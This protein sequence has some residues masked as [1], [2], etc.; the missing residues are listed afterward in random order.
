LFWLLVT[1]MTVIGLANILLL[2]IQSD[3]HGFDAIIFGITQ[4][5]GYLFTLDSPNGNKGC[6][7]WHGV[8]VSVSWIVSFFGWMIIP[9]TVGVVVGR[10]QSQKVL[11]GDIDRQFVNIATEAAPD[12]PVQQREILDRLRSNFRKF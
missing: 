6:G 5:A 8:T 4:T 9:V 7:F 1:S 2:A 12:D 11:L 10:S 3:L